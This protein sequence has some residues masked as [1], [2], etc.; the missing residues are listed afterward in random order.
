MTL[1][2]KLARISSKFD[3]LDKETIKFAENI[4]VTFFSSISHDLNTP[5]ALAAMHELVSKAAIMATAQ[6]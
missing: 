3:K 1:L 2:Q 6:E 5:E 4:R